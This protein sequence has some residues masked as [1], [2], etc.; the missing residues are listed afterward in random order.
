MS[1]SVKEESDKSMQEDELSGS[2]PEVLSH[3]ELLEITRKTLTVIL[4]QDPL[5]SDLPSGVTLE[6]VQAQIA[7]EH[8]QSMTVFVVRDDGEEMPVVVIMLSYN[9]IMNSDINCSLGIGHGDFLF[10]DMWLMFRITWF[11]DFGNWIYIHSN[12]RSRGGAYP[13]VSDR[14]S[15]SQF[16]V[17]AVVEE[18][19]L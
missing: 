8:G 5:L 13:F 16:V 3:Q 17:C 4:K 14:R 1:D 15:Y 10:K 19:S 2:E 9:Q 12:L 18:M 11:L 6:E 7:L